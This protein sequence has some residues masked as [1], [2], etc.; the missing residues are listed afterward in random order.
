MTARKTPTA[1][2]AADAVST[3]ETQPTTTLIETQTV[4]EDYSDADAVNDDAPAEPE[5][6]EAVE[7]NGTTVETYF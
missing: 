1:A 5:R 2:D 7:V 3:A 6:T 4:V